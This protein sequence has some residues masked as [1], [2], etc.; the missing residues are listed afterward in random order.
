MLKLF[1]RP[2]AKCDAIFRANEAENEVDPYKVR[3]DSTIYSETLEQLKNIILYF[4]DYYSIKN[5]VR[6]SETS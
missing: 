3:C 4:C 5:G 6:S 1:Q 2:G